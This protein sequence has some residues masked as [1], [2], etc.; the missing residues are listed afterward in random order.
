MTYMLKEKKDILIY[1]KIERLEE[2]KKLSTQEKQSQ[3]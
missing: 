3:K 2:N 1:N